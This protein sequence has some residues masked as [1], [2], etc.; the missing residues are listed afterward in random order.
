MNSLLD[1]ALGY[2][3]ERGWF[4]YPSPAKAGPAYVKWG[5]E[6]SRDPVV[7]TA[8]WRRWP[9]AL[10]CLDCGKSGVAA[11]DL[12]VKDHKRGP[13]ILHKLEA[14]HGKVHCAVRQRT[15]SGGTHLIFEGSIKTTV[16]VIGKEYGEG[17]DTR[18]RGGMIVLAPSAGYR[19]IGGDLP[20]TPLPSWLADLAGET[21]HRGEIGD[22]DFTPLYSDEEFA[23]LLNLIPVSRYDNDHDAWLELMLACSH[24]STVPNPES[25]FMQWTLADGPGNRIGYG[26]DEAM[27]QARWNY[28]SARSNRL[29][30]VRVGTFNRHVLRAA[31]NAPVKSPI[32]ASEDFA[33]GAEPAV[34]WTAVRAADAQRERERDYTMLGGKRVRIIRPRRPRG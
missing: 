27:I 20:L 14:T 29:H 7:I 23:A 10:T 26:C 31:P 4:I 28:N 8:W 3:I 11:I 9:T 21:Q 13:A 34:D 24:A 12:D 6:S 22:G 15:P 18:G 32:S 19:M 2:A 30:S 17:I 1:A 33:D 16:S 5:T 25:V